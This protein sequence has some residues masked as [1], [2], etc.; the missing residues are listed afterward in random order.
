MKAS[1]PL[2]LLI[3]LI[4]VSANAQVSSLSAQHFGYVMSQQ[5]SMLMVLD[6]RTNEIVKKV[7][8]ADMVR[9]A[10][11]SS[12]RTSS[13]TT[14]AALGRSRFGTRRTSPILCI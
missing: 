9:A 6:T 13:A 12:T 8:H 4:S 1:T 10:G 3:L 11:G 7:K 5:S 14:P 2:G